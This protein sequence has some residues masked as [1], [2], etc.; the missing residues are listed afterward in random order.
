MLAP[1]QSKAWPRAVIALAIIITI[2]WAG[3]LVWLPLHLLHYV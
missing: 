3:L 2:A 1:K